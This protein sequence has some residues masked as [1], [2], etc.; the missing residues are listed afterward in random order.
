[1]SRA[2]DCAT[3][4]T[5][6]VAAAFRRDGF[7][8]VARYLVQSGWKALTKE[9]ADRINAAGLNIISVFET[10]ASRALGGRAAGLDDGATAV[11]VAKQVGQPEGSTIY[12]AVDFDATAAHMPAVI[13][14]IRAASEAT[15]KFNTGVYGSAAV[16]KAVQKSGACSRYWQTYAWSR[17]E[18][19]PGIHIH[20]YDN[21]PKGIGKPMNGI[22]VD[23][24]ECYGNE[25]SW[26]T[27]K[28]APPVPEV[29]EYM[30]TA[31]D[32]NRIIERWLADEYN[33]ASDDDKDE[34]HRLAN[35]LRK[36]SGQPEQ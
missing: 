31:E 6:S 28:P 10:T 25:G 8:A 16:I 32:A 17:G 19:L 23:L 7:E 33:L 21:G 22:T 9:E 24:D 29:E 27:L 34:R 5:A 4:L 2:F 26:N 1:M 30:M 15:P 35:E 13:E 18:V 14:Y 11:Q 12:F 3:P 20:Q 36:A